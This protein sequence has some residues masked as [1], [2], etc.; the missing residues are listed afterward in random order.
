MVHAATF[1]QFQQT[2]AF[3]SFA[4]SVRLLRTAQVVNT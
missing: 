1:E 4:W 3:E 2:C